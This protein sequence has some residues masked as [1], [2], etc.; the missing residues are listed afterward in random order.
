MPNIKAC[1]FD[2][3]GVIVDTTKCHFQAWHKLL[4]SLWFLFY[5]STKRATE[6]RKPYA[7]AKYYYGMNGNGVI[8]ALVKPKTTLDSQ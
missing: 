3:D 1:I 5:P 8:L 4:Q 6:R 7:I 2:L